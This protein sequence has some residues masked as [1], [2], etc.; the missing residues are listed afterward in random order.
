[1]KV[2]H[3]VNGLFAVNTYY[4]VNEIDNTAVVIDGGVKAHKVLDFAREKG[5]TVTHMLLTHAHFDHSACSLELQKNGVK[6]G[7]CEREK[8]G[9]KIPAFNLSE[10]F[11]IPFHPTACDFTFSDGEVLSINGIDFKVIATPGHSSGS[12]CFLA[13]NRLFSGDTLMFETVG[14]TDLFGSSAVDLSESLKKLKELPDEI[15]VYPGHGD[16][17][18]IKHEKLYNPFMPL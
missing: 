13:E 11:N 3:Q 9:L 6:V 1:M 4:V 7:I 10:Y 2:Y 18:S 8:D 15:S 14:R 16:P 5:F 12:V 17:T